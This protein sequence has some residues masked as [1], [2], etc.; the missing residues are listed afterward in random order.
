MARVS[1]LHSSS[2]LTVLDYR[3]DATPHDAPFEEQHV[4]FSASYVR[5]GSFGYQLAGRAHELV[6]GATMLGHAGDVYACTHDHHLAGDECLSFQLSDASA[7]SLGL[8]LQAFR[9][10]ALPPLA[11]LSMLGELAQA[12]A[13]GRTDVGVDEVALA[14]VARCARLLSDRAERP[15][16]PSALD[17]RRAV[18]SALHIDE[19]AHEPLC[20]DDMAAEVGLS[21]YHYL[22]TFRHVLGVTPHQYLVRVRLRRAA[23]LLAGGTPVTRVAYD[24][25][26]GDLSNFVRTFTRAAGVSPGLFGRAARGE[27]A[28]LHGR[29]AREG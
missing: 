25:G 7:D 4:R 12:T 10:G 29:L 27:R 11:G 1:V 16:L 6:A 3:C 28:I 8:P 19:A 18:A 5:R 14:F 13:L 23:R 24:V 26:F 9:V 20:L 17:R 22:R 2:T 15:L 21:A